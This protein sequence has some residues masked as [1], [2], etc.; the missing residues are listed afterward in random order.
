MMSPRYRATLTAIG[1]LLAAGLVCHLLA[2]DTAPLDAAVARVALVPKTIG[3]W[4]GTDEPTD[5]ASFAQAGARGYW[6]RT[7]VNQRT[8]DSVLA[9]LMCGRAGKMAVHSPEVCYRGAGYELNEQAAPRSIKNERGEETDQF[10]SAQFTL[11]RPRINALA[12]LP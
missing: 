8:K 6:T 3:A 7:Y 4:Q 5:D 12:A 9:I 1:V 10:W 2:G 11:P